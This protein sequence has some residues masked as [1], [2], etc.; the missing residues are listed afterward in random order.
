MGLRFTYPKIDRPHRHRRHGLRAS[1]RR[2]RRSGR[3]R[4]DHDDHGRP[5]AV[6]DHDHD[7]EA[8]GDHDDVGPGDHDHDGTGDNDH[9]RGPGAR[10]PLDHHHHGAAAR[11]Q[12]AQHQCADAARR[13][14]QRQGR[15]VPEQQR[16]EVTGDRT[17][18]PELPELPGRSVSLRLQGTRHSHARR[19]R[20]L[21]A[22]ALHRVPRSRRAMELRCD[23]CR[24]NATARL[25]RRAPRDRV[26]GA[27]ARIG[28]AQPAPDL[29]ARDAGDDRRRS[30]NGTRPSPSST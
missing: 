7:D 23:R 15:A 24:Q 26:A 5:E 27:R 28:R 4:R 1:A 11:R 9:R 14:A 21:Q 2:G 10:R 16:R 13:H 3:R 17:E 18:R 19:Q 6:D 12:P 8:A 20:R 22:R 25:Q 29:Y 30:T